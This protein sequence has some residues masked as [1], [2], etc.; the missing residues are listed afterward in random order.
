M[1]K[2]GTTGILARRSI[3]WGGLHPVG[4]EGVTQSF[5]GCEPLVGIESQTA[6]EK[7]DKM[8]ELPGLR[9]IQATG[10]GQQAGTQ[11]TRRLDGC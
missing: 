1:G 4:E 5:R 8:I 11:V 9:V 3:A 7:V 2:H 6:L 10:C